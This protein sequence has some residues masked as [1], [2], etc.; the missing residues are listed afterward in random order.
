MHRACEH[1]KMA[2]V[3]TRLEYRSGH[4]SGRCTMATRL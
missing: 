4:R 2:L 1:L 3:A